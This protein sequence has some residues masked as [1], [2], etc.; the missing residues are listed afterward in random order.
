M[1]MISTPPTTRLLAT[2]LLALTLLTVCTLTGCAS[3]R[4]PPPTA[5]RIS[6]ETILSDIR[7]AVSGHSEFDGVSVDV[8]RGRVLLTGLAVSDAFARAAEQQARQVAGIV[9][10]D[11]EIQVGERGVGGYTS[12]N[13][14]STKVKT[15]LV[16]DSSVSGLSI[17]VETVRGTVYLVGVVPTVGERDAAVKI[18][19]GIHGVVKVVSALHV[20]AGS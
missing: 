12:D 3:R 16:A 7:K 14:I 6:D 9:A 15:A 11:N 10:L 17:S 20:E 8:I 13:W 19:R 5:A 4:D 2:R 1:G 18:A